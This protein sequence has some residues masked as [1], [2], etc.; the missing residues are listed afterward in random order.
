M[1]LFHHVH[2]VSHVP[3]S[4]LVIEVETI[5]FTLQRKHS[6]EQVRCWGIRRSSASPRL[7]RNS[8]GLRLAIVQDRPYPYPSNRPPSNATTKH[9]CGPSKWSSSSDP[10]KTE[11][12][13][14]D[15]LQNSCQKSQEQ[16]SID[17]MS[18]TDYFLFW[19]ARLQIAERCKYPSGRV[20]PDEVKISIRF[21]CIIRN[22][23]LRR[24]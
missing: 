19:K 16:R 12:D 7:P 14:R 23:P 10:D 13:G 1:L 8:F 22:H 21:A 2:V 5:F 4:D 6:R 18:S 17:L 20:A 15:P 24:E 9:A 3:H 11:S